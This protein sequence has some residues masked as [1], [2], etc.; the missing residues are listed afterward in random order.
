MYFSLYTGMCKEKGAGIG[1]GKPPTLDFLGIQGT[2]VD[3]EINML[4]VELGIK[5][6]SWVFKGLIDLRDNTDIL[7]KDVNSL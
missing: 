3:F 4:F 1:V 5:K 6:G 2:V 7:V